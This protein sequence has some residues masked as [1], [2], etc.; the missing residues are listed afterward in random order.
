[1]P[2]FFVKDEQVDGENIK[3]V[4][5]DVNHIV[6][7]LRLKKEDEVQIC[8]ANTSCYCYYKLIISVCKA[9]LHNIFESRGN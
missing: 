9:N 8:N 2:K 6:N 5:E 4:G 7:V 1:M 3:I